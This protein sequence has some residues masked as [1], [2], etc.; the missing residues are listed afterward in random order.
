MCF[1]RIFHTANLTTLFLTL[2]EIYV[3]IPSF[4][5]HLQLVNI[6]SLHNSSLETE[7]IYT[8]KIPCEI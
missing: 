2:Y 3:L 8:E 1:M 7:R 5:F 6:Y 4:S